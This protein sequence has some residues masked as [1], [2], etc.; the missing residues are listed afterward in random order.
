MADLGQLLGTLLASLAHARRIADE[1]TAAIAEYYRTNPLLEGMSLPRVRVPELVID[2]PLLIQDHIEGEPSQLEEDHH[3]RQSV[4]D[5]LKKAAL[6]EGIK[7][8]KTQQDSFD[9]ELKAEL[10]KFKDSD[11][12]DRGH[13]REMVVKAVDTALTRS[14]GD[15]KISQTQMRRLSFD[16][17]QRA[18]DVALKKP[19]QPSKITASMITSE[20]KENAGA[21]NVT[22]LKIVLREEGLE[23]STGENADGTVSRKLIPE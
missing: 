14:L 8:T 16:V 12:P 1:E 19:G 2:L 5:A 4:N 7:L 23:W 22:R 17:R 15:E 13:P 21:N 11:A 10:A 18:S 3:V 6:R 20:I 9:R